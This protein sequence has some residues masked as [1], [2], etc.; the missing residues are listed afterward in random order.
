MAILKPSPSSPRRLATGTR[1]PSKI[2]M[3][4]GWLFQPSFLSCLPKDMPGVSRGTT[5]L[6]MP[7]G[8]A[9]PVRHM[10]T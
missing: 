3:A 10:T 2:T 6:E 7:F 8:P 5:R 1:A 9:P 4:V